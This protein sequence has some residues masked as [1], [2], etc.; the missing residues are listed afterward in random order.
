MVPE[1]A[2]DI[3]HATEAKARNVKAR[4]AE[5]GVFHGLCGPISFRGCW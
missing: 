1:I 3:A 4:A 5:F 2:A